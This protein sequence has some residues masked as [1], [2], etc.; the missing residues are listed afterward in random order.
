MVDLLGRVMLSR[1]A[2]VF[3]LTLVR[4]FCWHFGMSRRC[5]AGPPFRVTEEA[6]G[7]IKPT[8]TAGVGIS[9]DDCSLQAADILRQE[10]NLP[11]RYGSG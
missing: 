7:G 4:V 9:A 6:V 1:G 8:R 11:H 10:A 3:R 5:V 2:T